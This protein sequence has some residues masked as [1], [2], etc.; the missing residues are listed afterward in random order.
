M[1][2]EARQTIR[3]LWQPFVRATSS[4]SRGWPN[5]TDASCRSTDT[6]CWARSRMPKIS[7]RT[8]SCGR[9]GGAP[10]PPAVQTRDRGQPEA[11]DAA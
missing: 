2:R 11:A 8:P 1:K 9:G 7:C 5:A 3:L 6:G 4:R 10:G